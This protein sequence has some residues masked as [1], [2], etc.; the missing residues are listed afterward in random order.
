MSEIKT[1]E[2]YVLARLED[3]EK[4][5]EQLKE[6][7]ILYTDLLMQTQKALDVLK[8]YAVIKSFGAHNNKYLTIEID[9]YGE[10][11]SDFETVC[12]ALK[13]GKDDE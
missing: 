10:S 11:Q 3:A 2:Q 1:C 6:E 12:E 8:K 13:I 9:G 4:E 7:Q 5:N